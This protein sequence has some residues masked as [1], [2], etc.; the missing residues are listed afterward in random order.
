MKKGEVDIKNYR[1]DGP[2]GQSRLVGST[3]CNAGLLSCLQIFLIV[4]K[5]A[6]VSMKKKREGKSVK[7]GRESD[8]IYPF[9]RDRAH[10]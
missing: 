10:P 5:P 4:R 3:M 2:E 8:L 7:D 6:K 1:Q 9:F